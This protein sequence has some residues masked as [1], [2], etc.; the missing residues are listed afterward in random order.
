MSLLEA[1]RTKAPPPL[2]LRLLA[3][4]VVGIVGAAALYALMVGI[5]NFDRIGV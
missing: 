3:G 4:L 2:W 1:S 5:E